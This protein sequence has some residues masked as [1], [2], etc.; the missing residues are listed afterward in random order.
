M[1]NSS[2]KIIKNASKIPG[3]MTQTTPLQP[4]NQKDPL[5]PISIILM[6]FNEAS[7]IEK[8]VRNFHAAIISKLPGSEF[9]VAEDGSTDGTSQI[10][11]TLHREGIITH[12]TSPER[13]GYQRAL[14]D[15]ITSSKKE[16]IFFSDTG[17]KHDPDDFWTLYPLRRRYDMI[18]GR[19][20]NRK[21]Q[22]YRRFFTWS[23]NFVVRQ[24]FAVDHVFDCDSGFKFFNRVVA[25]TVYGSNK[26]FFKGFPNSEVVL[27]TIHS[28]LTYYEVPISYSQRSG[29]SRGLPP[30]RIPKEVWR[31]IRN[32]RRLKSEFQQIPQK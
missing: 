6:A 23:Y 8:E 18:V 31:V 4:V 17:L 15:A 9:I 32:L 14:L 27:R 28:G 3:Q 19:K 2:L 16:Y 7:T 13:K 20:T 5:D 25:Q 21:D 12:L 11:Q 24:Y 10:L 1:V 29:T 26:L 22:L 30:Q